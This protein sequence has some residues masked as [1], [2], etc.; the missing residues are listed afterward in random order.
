V[1]YEGKGRGV[2]ATKPFK[3]GDFV[4]EYA[5]DL[6]ELKEAKFREETYQKD[7]S[8]GCYMY[9]FS[10]RGKSYW[11]VPFPTSSI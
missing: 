2:Q 1:N 10:H 5:G 8:C 11:W 9:F 3:K 4:V 6:V 7:I